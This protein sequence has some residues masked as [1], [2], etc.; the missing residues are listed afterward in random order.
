MNPQFEQIIT[1]LLEK[2]DP[3]LPEGSGQDLEEMIREFP[4]V[5]SQNKNDLGCFEVTKHCIDTGNARP[6]RQPLRSQPQV[7]REF[8]DETVEQMMKEELIEPAQSERAANVVLVKK[9][10]GT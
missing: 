1:T 6:V 9:K 4:D 3:S 5:F 7:Y 10:D 8:I 2:V